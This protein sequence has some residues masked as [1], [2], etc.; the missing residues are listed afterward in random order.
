VVL[1]V[2]FTM[3]RMTRSMTVFACSF[4]NQMIKRTVS[5]KIQ[6]KPWKMSRSQVGQLT[7]RMETIGLLREETLLQATAIKLLGTISHKETRKETSKVTSNVKKENTAGARKAKKAKLNECSG[8]GTDLENATQDSGELMGELPESKKEEKK[9]R[10]K[11]E[12]EDQLVMFDLESTGLGTNAAQ[13]IQIAAVPL[14]KC[15]QPSFNRFIVPTVSIHWGATMVH[16]MKVK[17][18]CLVRRGEDLEADVDAATVLADFF[19]WCSSLQ[20]EKSV[21]LVAHNGARFDFPLL[22]SAATRLGVRLPSN[23][24]NLRLA[25]SLPACKPFK[26]EFGNCKLATLKRCLVKDGGSQT[27]DALDD[28][29]DLGEVLVALADKSRQSIKDLLRASGSIKGVDQYPVKW[30]G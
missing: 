12:D 16:G 28:C 2:F 24:Q 6:K 7:K 10:E 17:N 22:F 5:N 30:E 15:G 27:H 18:G 1:V 13:I 3:A 19:R 8:A 21:V 26:L 14:G 25:D 20:E 4:Q 29:A 23:L 11:E 9:M